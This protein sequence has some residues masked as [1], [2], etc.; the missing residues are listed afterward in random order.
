[1][2]SPIHIGA[3]PRWYEY[4]NQR[5]DA[6]MADILQALQY[7]QQRNDQRNA[8]TAEMFF[9]N[10]SLIG[11]DAWNDWSSKAGSQYGDLIGIGNELAA[12]K[13]RS[14][15]ERYDAYRYLQEGARGNS[16][17]SLSVAEPMLRDDPGDLF[18]FT[19]IQPGTGPLAPE[20]WPEGAP[21]SQA[22]GIRVGGNPV[23]YMMDR[24]SPG[25]VLEV[26]PE[27]LGVLKADT[28][29]Q[30]NP[31]VI[32]ALQPD[33]KNYAALIASNPQLQGDFAQSLS[34]ATGAEMNAD[35][36]ARLALEQ[37][38]F[39][40]GQDVDTRRLDETRRHNLT[41]EG[42]TREKNAGDA[43]REDSKG[44]FKFDPKDYAS[45]L[46]GGF[47]TSYDEEG[48]PVEEGLQGG[49]D[50]STATRIGTIVSQT[51]AGL[52]PEQQQAASE[53]S[54]EQFRSAFG[55]FMDDA[56]SYFGR[57]SPATGA[58]EDDGSVT[59]GRSTPS[60]ALE[61]KAKV[62]AQ[63]AVLLYA[64]ELQKIS[65]LAKTREEGNELRLAAFNKAREYAGWSGE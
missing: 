33:V 16:E 3:D 12:Q 8:Q 11:T 42:L 55:Y 21:A 61:A 51:V 40:W 44:A 29:A 49:I 6:A 47:E 64:R 45:A 60:G 24:A 31:G 37:Q 13:Q 65:K 26:Y 22:P 4:Q 1:M 43:A 34:L 54:L 7:R 10:P 27:L 36:A 19:G 14:D 38:K 28:F 32:N 25:A 30:G 48:K 56:T 52:P 53:K 46:S 62:R 2:G 23:N 41:T 63:Q 5:K 18:D 58:T 59:G 57:L 39:G 35:Q 17:A 15:A 50:K 9:K 20:F